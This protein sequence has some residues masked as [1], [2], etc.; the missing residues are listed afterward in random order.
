MNRRNFLMAAMAVPLRGAAFGKEV[1]GANTAMSGYG[2]Y[3]AIEA[4]RR[5]GFPAIEIHPMGMIEPRPGQYPGFEFGALSGIEKAKIRKSLAG[6][7]RI[8]T[9]LPY[10]GLSPFAADRQ[11]A[12]HSA[13]KIRSAMEATSF[14]GAELAVLHVIAPKDRPLAEAWPIM[15]RQIREWG[16]YAARHNFKLA[17]ETGFPASIAEFVRLAREIDHKAVGCTID[18]GHQHGY[19]ELVAKVKPEDRASPAGIRAYND[20]TNEIIDALGEKVFHLHVHDID[21]A[22][23][24]EH[25]PIGTGFVDY[26]RLIAN[27]RRIGY[28]GLL[29]LEIGGPESEIEALLADS[30]RKLEAFL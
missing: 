2:L 30:K 26:P 11:L 24:A 1:V 8:T 14:F 19:K 18:V 22:T 27:L 13:G 7:R 20:T 12:E 4:I 9:H 3:Q 6:F 5:L 23:W 25:K 28:R 16:D 15:V 17:F 10:I 21:P 29:M